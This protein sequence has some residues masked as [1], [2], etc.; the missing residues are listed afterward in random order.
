MWHK[1]NATHSIDASELNQLYAKIT[2]KILSVTFEV[3]NDKK[4]L[5]QSDLPGSYAEYL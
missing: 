1:E 4:K 3:T 2:I 5:N